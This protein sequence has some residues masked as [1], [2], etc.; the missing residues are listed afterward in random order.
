L[1]ARAF[2]LA[3]NLDFLRKDYQT[4]VKSYDSALKLAPGLEPDASDTIGRD[5]AHNR[6]IALRRIKEQEDKKK[7]EEKPDSGPPDAGD[8][9]QDQDNKD[10]DKDKKEEQEQDGGAP[11]Q[12]PDA[13]A[14]PDGGAGDQKQDEQQQEKPEQDGSAPPPQEQQPPSSN[15]DERI[16]EQL[17]QAPT[18]QEHD[19]KNRALTGRV[20]GMEDK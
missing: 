13:G 14:Q 5:A 3:G 11:E 9:N 4:A 2:Y 1:R 17:E 19:A 20:S 16:L 7:D 6:S 15:Q 18:V 8:Q 12:K 10:K